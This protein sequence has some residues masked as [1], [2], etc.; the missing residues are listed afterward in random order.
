MAKYGTGRKTTTTPATGIN[1]LWWTN[2]KQ[3]LGGPWF[4]IGQH[5]AVGFRVSAGVF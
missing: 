1:W 5:R 4:G 3:Y 2:L